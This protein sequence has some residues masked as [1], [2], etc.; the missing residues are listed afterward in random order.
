MAVPDDSRLALIGYGEGVTHGDRSGES[1]SE[2]LTGP[3]PVSHKLP[4]GL[5]HVLIDLL[6]VVLH[7]ACLRIVLLVVYVGASH[8]SALL[9]EQQGFR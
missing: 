6:G 5:Y 8:N 4:D 1:F 7:P 9:I 2:G 3:V